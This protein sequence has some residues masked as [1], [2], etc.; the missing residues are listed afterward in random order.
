MNEENIGQEGGV[1]FNPKTQA[2][3]KSKHGMSASAALILG[4]SLIIVAVIVMAGLVILKRPNV[5]TYEYSPKENQVVNEQDV[6]LE[7]VSVVDGAVSQYVTEIDPLFKTTSVYQKDSA[8]ID[9]KLQEGPSILGRFSS[10]TMGCGSS[11]VA[12]FYLIDHVN[13]KIYDAKDLQNISATSD[14]N[15]VEV[16]KNLGAGAMAWGDSRPGDPVNKTLYRFDAYNYSFTPLRAWGC[17]LGKDGNSLDCTESEN[18]DSVPVIYLKPIVSEES[19]L[20]LPSKYIK[21][22]GTWPPV[23]QYFNTPYRCDVA[24]DEMSDT[25]SITINGKNY[26]K[27]DQHEGATG[28]IYHTYTYKTPSGDGINSTSFVL[29]YDSCGVYSSPEKEQCQS[30]QSDFDVDAIADS[31]LL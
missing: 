21:T 31:I 8:I 11:C 18:V 24:S 29:V 30:V 1:E 14:P 26:C 17:T 5:N 13:G 2:V 20:K 10:V 12:D 19:A 3:E 25:Y 15:I 27:T 22:E 23:L 4:I 28:H 16:K 7:D 6:A 9:Q